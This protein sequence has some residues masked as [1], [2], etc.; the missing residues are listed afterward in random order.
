MPI[1]NQQNL[2]T[3]SGNNIL[4]QIGG[5]TIGLI[6]NVRLSED[7]GQ[8]PASGVGDASVVEYVPGMAR[9][10]LSVSAMVLRSGSLRSADIAPENAAGALQGLVLDFL[11]TDKTTGALLRKYSGCSYNSGDVEVSKHAIVMSTGQFNWP[12][13]S[14]S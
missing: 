14:W 3:Q 1:Q 12:A 7:Y 6:Q 2:Q 4:V 13:G 9:Y 11:V 5:V 8:E 10:S